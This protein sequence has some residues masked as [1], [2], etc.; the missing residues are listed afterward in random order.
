MKRL[1]SVVLGLGLLA[2]ACGAGSG[3]LGPAPSAS[4]SASPSP[5][6][7][8]PSPTAPSAPSPTPSPTGRPFTFEVWFADQDV[9]LFVSYRT[10]P[11]V[12]GVARLAITG[13]LDGP[14]DAELAAGISS[15]IPPGTALRDISI[16]GTGLLTVDLSSEFEAP[17]GSAAEMMRLAEVV[18]TGSQFNT[19]TGVNFRIEGEPITA[20]ASHGIVLDHPQTRDDFESLLP[21]ILVDSPSIGQ[22][23]SS[24]VTVSGTANVFEATVSLRILDGAGNEIAHT[25]TTATCGTGCRGDYSVSIAYSVGTEQPG[26]IEVFESSAQDGS[27]INVVR[28][29]VKLAP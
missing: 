11:F 29:P 20:F 14:T 5:S 28:I 26:V 25:F 27:P 24:P 17:S 21:A 19:V 23:V 18:Y 2:A 15:A 22:T 9:H 3:S 8:T 10:E 1:T 7:T 6:V 13:L 4:P 16:D 12:Q